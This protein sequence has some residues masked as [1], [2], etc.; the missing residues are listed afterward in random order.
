LDIATVEQELIMSVD[1]STG[2]VVLN[3]SQIE[4]MYGGSTSVAAPASVDIFFSQVPALFSSPRKISIDTENTSSADGP[5]FSLPADLSTSLLSAHAAAGSIKVVAFRAPVSDIWQ[6]EGVGKEAWDFRTDVGGLTLHDGAGVE[7]VVMNLTTP[8]SLTLFAN[9]GR[10]ITPTTECYYLD[11]GDGTRE[12]RWSTEGVTVSARTKTSIV[13]ET[14]HLSAFAAAKNPSARGPSEREGDPP[15][16]SLAGAVGGRG[17]LI[18]IVFILTVALYA[19]VSFIIVRHKRRKNNSLLADN[20]DRVAGAYKVSAVQGSG[21][22]ARIVT[23]FAQAGG[24]E[25]GL[26]V[27]FAVLSPQRVEVGAQLKLRC[28]VDTPQVRTDYALTMYSLC[29][30]Y[31]LTMY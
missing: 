13:C 3:G 12:A 25:L 11:K 15:Y 14:T 1:S 4:S 31:A 30:H 10:D 18:P 2:P 9:E 21:M 24:A 26:D 8:I 16:V 7:I 22:V 17:I 29:T 27:L 23:L 20:I 5:Y 19:F 6:D 28:Y